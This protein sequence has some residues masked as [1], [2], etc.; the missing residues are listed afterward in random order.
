MGHGEGEATLSAEHLTHNRT[1]PGRREDDSTRTAIHVLTLTP[2]FP[3]TDN[4]VNGCFIKEPIDRLAGLGVVS[5]VYAVSPFYR[6]RR[7]AIPSATADWVRYPQL[8][9]NPGLADSGWF[10]YA[11][12]LRKVRRLHQQTPIDLIH[13]HAALPCGHASMRLS[14][15]LGIPYVV[16]VHGL[17][18]FHTLVAGVSVQRRQK[19]SIEVY[20][21]ARTVI[22]ISRRVQEILQNGMQGAVRSGVVYNGVDEVMFSPASAGA[23]PWA[24]QQLLVAGN[25]IPSKCQAL[26]LRAMARLTGSFPQ[27]RCQFIGDGPDRARLEMLSRQLG[28]AQRVEFLGRRSRREVADAMRRCSAFVLP[29]R[30]EGL[31]CVY[32]E[33]M[34]CAK[35]VIACRGQGIEEIIEHGRNGWL[36]P[37]DGFDELV[38]TLATLLGSRDLCARLG[39]TARETILRGFT[40]AHQAEALTR[41]Y[42]DAITRR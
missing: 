17:D 18:V 15:R 9:G 27:L 16:T 28:I 5:S 23:D 25:L 13:A 29:S 40:L 32:L 12:L 3:S 30:Y 36:I 10:L 11:R 42:Q 20:H 2:F 38:Q 24:R 34:A 19:K 7:K 14:R 6:P 37:P 22:C 33:A 21:A 4:E 39:Q 41:I 35:P 31:G 26:V 1:E 8:P